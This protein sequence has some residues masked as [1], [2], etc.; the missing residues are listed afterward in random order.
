MILVVLPNELKKFLAEIEGL[1]FSLT[2]VGGAVRDFLGHQQL[3]NDL[4]FEIS[5]VENL[6]TKDWCL[7]YKKLLSFLDKQKLK[8]TELP[9]LITRTEYSGFKLEFAGPR[10]EQ[11]IADDITHHHF[12]AIM[13]SQLSFEESFKRRDLSINAI[14]VQFS[15]KENGE[16]LIDPYNGVYDLN[17]KLIRNINDDF[18]L[19]NVRFL[20]LLR[21]Q[22]KFS[23]FLTSSELTLNLRKFNL[24]NLSAYHFT[25]ELFKSNP[26]QFL[27][28][29]KA[30]VLENGLD[31]PEDFKIWTKYNFPNYLKTKDEILGFVFLKDQADAVK[32][33]RFFTMPEKKLRDLESFYKSYEKLKKLKKDDF[34]ALL[35][36]PIEVALDHEILKELKNSDEKKEWMGVLHLSKDGFF[37]TQLVGERCQIS[38][39]D[40]QKVKPA[41]RSYLPYY[42]KIKM[43]LPND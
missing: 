37:L 43:S 9:Y 15:F 10:L 13:I 35:S 36:M 33:L 41:L 32:V 6:S 7:Y 26:G 29:F 4:D 17:H 5:C 2:L 40:L 8:Y 25:E 11:H 18:F 38:P 12:E 21:F 1:G 30:S 28:H 31:I 3:G 27:N 23:D 42:E 20:R 34:Y 24:R 22:I 16:K 19:D 39:Q 14:G